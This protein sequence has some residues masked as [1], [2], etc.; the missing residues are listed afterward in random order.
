M[1][2]LYVLILCAFALNAYSAEQKKLTDEQ[3]NTLFLFNTASLAEDRCGYK[4]NY[5]HFKLKYI[6]TGLT[7]ELTDP[8][9]GYENEVALAYAESVDKMNGISCDVLPDLF[10]ANGKVAPGI[11]LTE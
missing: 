4:M 3:W 9:G 1:K 7:Q 2:K 5:S 10:G 8:N 6:E 11:L